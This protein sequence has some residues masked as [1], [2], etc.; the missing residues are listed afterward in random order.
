MPK[1]QTLLRDAFAKLQ[2]R[3]KLANFHELADGAALLP[4][5]AAVLARLRTGMDCWV[6]KRNLHRFREFA[7]G[8]GLSTRV[9]CAFREVPRQQLKR[10]VGSET[11]CTTR[12]YG[13]RAEDADK[14]DRIHVF[15]GISKYVAEKL[16]S[17]G[18]YPLVINDRVFSKPALDHLQFGNSL[19]YPA[20]CVDFF[21]TC[22]DWARTNSYAEAYRNT[23]SGFDY[24][25]NCFGKNLGYSFVSH[26]PCRFDCRKT[27]A[28]AMQ[29]ESWLQRWEPEFAAACRELL[30]KPVLSL[31]EHEIVVLEGRVVDGSRAEY[32]DAMNLFATDDSTMRRIKAGNV[33][34]LRGRFV[35]ILRGTKVVD[36]LECRCDQFGPR[37]PLLIDWRMGPTR[38]ARTRGA[39]VR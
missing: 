31:N 5:F 39:A 4:Q 1:S 28:F 10:M 32:T 26:I 34:E 38:A 8:L 6:R 12:A 30:V 7:A 2:P 19:G 17:C 9:D 27:V 3:G 15:V 36:A 23:D 37:V 14:D 21:R 11:L 18:W 20:C 22:N 24:L 13:V 29:L 25:A 16:R 35:A 33:I